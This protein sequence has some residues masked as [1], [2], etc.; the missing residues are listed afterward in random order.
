MVVTA[1]LRGR[2]TTA[3]PPRGVGPPASPASRRRPLE[4]ANGNL[5]VTPHGSAGYYGRDRGLGTDDMLATSAGLWIA[6]DNQ[7][8]SQMCGGA[9]NLSGICFLPHSG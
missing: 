9:Q 3:I 6:S 5:Y 4:A 7:S 8:G 2:L 1:G